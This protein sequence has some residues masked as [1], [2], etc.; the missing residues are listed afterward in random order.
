MDR[1]DEEVR[2]NGW[3]RRGAKRDRE[4]EMRKEAGRRQEIEREGTDSQ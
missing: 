2:G 4:G 1:V 3:K